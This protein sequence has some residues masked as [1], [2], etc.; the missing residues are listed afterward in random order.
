MA[1]ESLREGEDKNGFSGAL[2]DVFS[3]GITFYCLTHFKLP[4]DN[5][6]IMELFDD[7]FQKD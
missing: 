5:G 4:F 1:P 6:N 2:A 3:L 7:I